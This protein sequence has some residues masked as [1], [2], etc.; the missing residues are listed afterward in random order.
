VLA[1]HTARRA[2][3]ARAAAATGAVFA[4]LLAAPSAATARVA[5]QDTA[6]APSYGPPAGSWAQF[7]S[8]LNGAEGLATGRGVTIALLSTGADPAAPGM[9][10]KVSNGPD[11]IFKPQISQVHMLGTLTAGLIAGVPG[12]V[13][14]IAPDA[15]IMAIRVEPDEFEPGQ[16]AFYG[17]SGHVDYQGINAAAIRYAVSHGAQVILFDPYTYQAPNSALLSAVRYALSKNVVIVTGDEASPDMQS[18]MYEY[19]AGF[20]GVIGIGAITLPGGPSTFSNFLNVSNNSLLVSTPANAAIA[21]Q[22]GWQLDGFAT[23]DAYVAATVALIKERYPG[24]T[25]GQVARALAISARYHPRGGYSPSAGFGVLDSYD[26]VLDAARVAATTP[27]AAPGDGGAV[28]DGVRFGSAPGVISALPS[29]GP[30]ADLYPVLVGLGAMLLVA[31]TVLAAR[32]RPGRR[33]PQHSR[34]AQ[35]HAPGRPPYPGPPYPGPLHPSQPY[36]ASGYSAAGPLGPPPTVP[37]PVL[38]EHPGPR[39]PGPPPRYQEPPPY[40]GSL[41]GP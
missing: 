27:V 31:G 14:G 20:P 6:T 39:Y 25:P 7:Q 38:P 30:V 34:Q 19:P 13:R 33:R 17:G 5:A 41:T 29:A 1:A 22:D 16:A 21:S 11:Y 8:D 37:Q 26:A 18:W 40:G 3:V 24:I 32:R 36:P 9:A 12:A 23:A 35:S 15:H 2:R 4:A 28:A 10:G